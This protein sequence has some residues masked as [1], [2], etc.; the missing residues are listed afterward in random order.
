VLV[1][2]SEGKA[3][4][5]WSGHST[6]KLECSFWFTTAGKFWKQLQVNVLI[7]CNKICSIDIVDLVLL[8]RFISLN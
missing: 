8:V 3:I 2:S 4:A 7:T 5:V 6:C 1:E